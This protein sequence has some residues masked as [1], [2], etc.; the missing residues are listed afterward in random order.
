MT[1]STSLR[2]ESILRGLQPE[3]MIFIGLLLCIL[4]A[5]FIVRWLISHLLINNDINAKCA[6]SAHIWNLRV[7]FFLV[8]VVLI[9]LVINTAS[10]VTNTIPQH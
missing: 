1:P 3:L 10:N 9:G 8:M 5:F 2:L 4:V 7:T 6:T